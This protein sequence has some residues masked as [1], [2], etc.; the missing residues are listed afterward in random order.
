M[1]VIDITLEHYPKMAREGFVFATNIETNETL[2]FLVPLKYRLLR[3]YKHFGAIKSVIKKRLPAYWENGTR[4]RRLIPVFVK[5][6][7]PA[8]LK[9]LETK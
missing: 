1:N 9:T 3:T 7:N 5:V 2:T 4:D 8:I 6:T